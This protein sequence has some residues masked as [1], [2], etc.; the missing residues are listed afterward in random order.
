MLTPLLYILHSGGLFGTERMAIATALG[1]R[2]EYA[3]ILFAPPGAALDE[4]RRCGLAAESF[5]SSWQLVCK[6][7]PLFGSHCKLALVA[8]GI[9]HSL[10]GWALGVLLMCKVRHLH[11]VHGG[12]DEHLSYGRKK[13]INRLPVRFVAVSDFVRQRLV[14]HGVARGAIAVIEN[15]LSSQALAR[16]PR[17]APFAASGVR[18]AL[19]VSRIDPIKQVDLLF[20]VLDLFPELGDFPITVFGTGWNLDEY[21]ARAERDYPNLS[22]AGFHSDVPAMLAGSDLLIHTCPQEPF[23]LAILE[24]FAAG[25][26]VVAPNSGGASGLVEEGISGFHYTAG[27]PLALGELLVKMRH[28]EPAELNR[29]VAHARARLASR[30]SAA[31]GIARYRDVLAGV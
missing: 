18:E 14:A 16:A 11:V 6:L 13:L 21:R 27:D 29:I 8:T 26:P 24:A 3:P 19:V 1:L 4:A 7:F 15:F 12:A 5:T 25:V 2:G 20:D 31:T 10:I 9:S 28:F 23:G 30:Y 22:F 17:R